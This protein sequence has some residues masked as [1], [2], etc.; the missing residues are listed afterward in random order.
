MIADIL[1]R[2]QFAT[3]QAE[4]EMILLPLLRELQ[5]H[6]RAHCEPFARL[7]AGLGI[8]DSSDIT[9]MAD[10]PALPVRLFKEHDLKS[11]DADDVFK[12]LTSS[13]TTGQ[14][15][16]RISLD[17]AATQI[18]S[19]ALSRT[20]SEVLGTERLPMLIIDSGAVLADRQSF[21][22]RGAGV[23]G[24][25]SFGRRH[26][27]AL[28]DDQRL[29]LDSVRSFLDEYGDKPFLIFGFTYMVWLHLYGPA[30]EAGLDLS[31]GVLVHSGGW[32][33]LVDQ[34]VSPTDFRRLLHE[35]IGLSL[36]H[37][38]YG[39]VEQI[40][41]VFLEGPD[42][43]GSLYAPLF[44]DVII[45]DPITWEPVE[46][47]GTGIIEV[48]SLLPR[49]Y[50]GHAL[51]TEDIGQLIGVDDGPTWK[52]KRF[53]VIGRVPLAEVRGCSDTYEANS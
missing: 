38:F 37:N 47:G 4:K 39:M 32:K 25:M 10:L 42:D 13:G 49:S 12:V 14:A 1:S 17:R 11:I 46:V 15:V 50:P 35:G 31:N 48:V 36:V 33:Q 52:G 26:T 5:E 44:S 8:G 43:P 20:M 29:D 21:N 27:Y 7:L 41:T 19:R 53:R 18:Q 24:M 28:D 2:P 6:H 22:A 9:T 45:R 34:A 23:A 16:S 40:G 30:V 3:S 51:L